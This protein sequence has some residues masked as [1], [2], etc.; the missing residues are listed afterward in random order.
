LR[1]RK[2][3]AYDAKDRRY[4]SVAWAKA[5]GMKDRG[6]DHLVIVPRASL[7]KDA[8]LSRAMKGVEP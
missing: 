1:E 6:G 5:H 4:Y 7:P 2:R 3:V 8:R